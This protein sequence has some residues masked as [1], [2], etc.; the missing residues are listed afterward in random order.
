[1][2]HRSGRGKSGEEPGRLLL[3]LCL[4]A[5]LAGVIGWVTL[6]PPDQQPALAVTLPDKVYHALAFAALILPSALLA[7]QSLPWILGA[8][9]AYGGLIEL[10]QPQVGRS[11]EIG[12]MVANIVG[13]CAGLVIGWGLRRLYRTRLAARDLS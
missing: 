2:T 12:D 8:G 10:I 13:L 7:V 4:T 6:T 5:L 9:L 3:A 1:M 11:S